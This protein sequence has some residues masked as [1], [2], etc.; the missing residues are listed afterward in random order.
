MRRVPPL[1][2]SL[3]NSLNKTV[4]LGLSLWLGVFH[5]FPAFARDDDWQSYSS[6]NRYQDYQNQYKPQKNFSLTSQLDRQIQN[7]NNA[8]QFRFGQRIETK[9]PTFSFTPSN[10]PT[11][12]QPKF[13]FGSQAPK[14]VEGF[15]IDIPKPQAISRAEPRG[16]LGAIGNGIKAVANTFALAFQKIGQTIGKVVQFFSVDKAKITYQVQRDRVL[17]ENPNI[18][19]VSRGTFQVPQGQTAQIGGRAWEPG[20]TFQMNPNGRG[21]GLTEGVTMSPDLGGIRRADGNPLPVKMIGENGGFKP[22][23]IDFARIDPKTNFNFTHPVDMEGVGKIPAGTSMTYEAMKPGTKEDPTPT[24]VLSF[25]NARIENPQGPLQALGRGKEPLTLAQAEMRLKGAIYQINSLRLNRGNEKLYTSE[26][27]EVFSL[28]QL[29][30]K[31]SSVQSKSADLTRQSKKLNDDTAGAVN[32]SNHHM[33]RLHEATGTPAT[34]NFQTKEPIKNQAETAK[35]LQTQTNALAQHMEQGNYGEV[36]NA[37][38]DIET[39][40]KALTNQIKAQ[41]T[42][43]GTYQDYKRA[44]KGLE[45]AYGEM[46]SLANPESM[47]GAI[48]EDRINGAASY[49]QGQKIEIQIQATNAVKALKSMEKQG[50]INPAERTLK[51]AEIKAIHDHLLAAKPDLVGNAVIKTADTLERNYQAVSKDFDEAIFDHLDNAAEKY[52]KTMQAVGQGALAVAGGAAIVGLGYGLVTA[53]A[54]TVAVAGSGVIS[55]KT[56]EAM[57]LPPETAAYY[58]AIMTAPVAAVAEGSPLIAEAN[59]SGAAGIKGF[60]SKIGQ[61]FSEAKPAA[62]QLVTGQAGHVYIGE[63]GQRSTAKSA[64][65]VI[66]T[67]PTKA[68]NFQAQHTPET[69]G[70]TFGFKTPREAAIGFRE[71]NR[72]RTADDL[73]VIGQKADALVAEEWPKH[74]ILNINDAEWTPRVND[75]WI[76]GGIDRKATFYLGSPQNGRTLSS[77]RGESIFAREINQ[78]R[79]A[80]YKQDG[81]FLVPPK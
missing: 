79:K 35:T 27:G 66:E 17:K 69:L 6:N 51:V 73:I 43:L 60:L 13:Q 32:L 14:A 58:T 65:E 70:K 5:A 74:Q 67:L 41:Q 7:Q 4:S 54:T 52:P 8:L 25:Q 16:F 15:K 33:G 48:T 37:V 19:E 31:K 24:V 28:T 21:I 2:S 47:K 46:A 23:G 80:G 42:Q 50:I 78:L 12:P 76:Q 36:A 53:P 38:T 75:S 57:G 10:S 11:L 61:W 71:Y 20:S 45:R 29:E 3:G 56:F 72:A 55:Q 30:H 26:R 59:K 1:R 44:V 39:T 64:N 63:I 81:D 40:Q 18:R 77:S 68:S 9:T 62:K 22:I 34:V 49:F